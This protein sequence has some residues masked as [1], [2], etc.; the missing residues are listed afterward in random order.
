[1]CM[2]RRAYGNLR[3]WKSC[4]TNVLWND[5]VVVEARIPL[6]MGSVKKIAEPCATYVTQQV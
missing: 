6:I 1:M 2:Y 4:K 5:A 3:L